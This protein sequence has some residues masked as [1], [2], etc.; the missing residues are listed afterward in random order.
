MLIKNKRKPK[1]QMKYE[2]IV[3][4]KTLRYG[5]EFKRDKNLPKILK[6]SFF[7][8]VRRYDIIHGCIKNDDIC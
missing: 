3:S 5:K 4:K 6:Q 2:C 7:K 8:F 1:N